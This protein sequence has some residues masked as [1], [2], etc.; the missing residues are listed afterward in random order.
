MQVII[1]I[2]Y[3]DE[4][5]EVDSGRLTVIAHSQL[6][7]I[8]TALNTEAPETFPFCK[9]WF[10]RSKVL[11]STMA[12][13]NA[14][15]VQTGLKDAFQKESSPTASHLQAIIKDSK[16]LLSQSS[17]GGRRQQRLAEQGLIEAL[18]VNSRL[19]QTIYQALQ[20]VY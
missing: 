18:E 6:R 11:Q 3:M 16:T 5:A 20:T 7:A 8:L 2:Q 10:Y 17:D 15:L 4:L 9:K 12:P 1:L 19:F 13:R 14:A